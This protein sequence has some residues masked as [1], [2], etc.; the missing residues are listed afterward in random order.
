V[1]S[2]SHW[3]QTIP[4]VLSGGVDCPSPVAKAMKKKLL[5]NNCQSSIAI[6]RF[7]YSSAPNVVK[8]NWYAQG[9]WLNYSL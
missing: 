4:Q 6:L 8:M 1:T 5:S 2:L 3:K 7:S 9:G